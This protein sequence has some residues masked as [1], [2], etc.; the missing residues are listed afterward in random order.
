MLA[1]VRFAF[2]LSL[3]LL[4]CTISTDPFARL[5]VSGTATQGGEPAPVR[6]RL[7]AGNFSTARNFFDG[8]YSITVGGGGVPASN[9]SSAAVRARL[10]DSDGETVLDEEVRTLGEC[11]EHVVDFAFR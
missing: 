5:T 3:V 2:F 8:S 10:L 11:G 9:C 6:I 7:T 1:P 4:S